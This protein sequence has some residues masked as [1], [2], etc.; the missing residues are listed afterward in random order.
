MEFVVVLQR[1]AEAVVLHPLEAGPMVGGREMTQGVK[2]YPR[3][4]SLQ[5][6]EDNSG[7]Q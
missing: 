5:P 2:E 3:K 1:E 4:G 7:V 6:G